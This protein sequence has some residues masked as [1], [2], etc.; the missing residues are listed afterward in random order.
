MSSVNS[1]ASKYG[2]VRT[3]AHANMLVKVLLQIKQK[4]SL[5]TIA[6]SIMDVYD[7]GV[8]DG[9][10]ENAEEF[11]E[12]GLCVDDQAAVFVEGMSRLFS[13]RCRE[14]VDAVREECEAT[15]KNLLENIDFHSNKKRRIEE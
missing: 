7:Q 6:E 15:S 11:E 10:R 13:E 14:F 1:I 5:E 4:K 12:L 2:C 9:A 3:D 8:L